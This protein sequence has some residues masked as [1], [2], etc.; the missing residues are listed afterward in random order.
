MAKE[1][2]PEGDPLLGRLIAAGTDRLSRDLA[3]E[4]QTTVVRRLRAQYGE[5]EV[6]NL[7]TKTAM[8]YVL[9]ST[10]MP[11]I[12]F[13]SSFVSN[14][15]DERRLRSPHFQQAEADAIV[16]AIG[17]WFSRQKEE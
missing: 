12:L 6:T 10:R 13:E 15:E 4:V 8:F 5:A 2:S 11:A 3:H 1:W 7:G 17:A 16:E 14:V 9:V